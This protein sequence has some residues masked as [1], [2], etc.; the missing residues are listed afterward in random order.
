MLDAL[1]RYFDLQSASRSVV[2]EGQAR[3]PTAPV[4]PQYLVVSAGVVLEPFLHNYASNG[5]WQFD[6]AAA[7]GRL[8]FGLI[9]GVI[10]LPGAYKSAFDPKKP[11]AVQLAALFPLGIGW[12]SL[13]SAVMKGGGV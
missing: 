7:A 9:V 11:I 6:W 13:F 2:A 1:V 12:Q 5:S 10:I 4:L 3:R 8:V